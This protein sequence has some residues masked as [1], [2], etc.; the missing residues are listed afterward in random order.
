[1]TNKKAGLLAFFGATSEQVERGKRGNDLTRRGGRKGGLLLARIFFHSFPD[2][3]LSEVPILLT[4]GERTQ[5][6]GRVS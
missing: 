5:R 3:F 1:M 4:L 6:G 2:L